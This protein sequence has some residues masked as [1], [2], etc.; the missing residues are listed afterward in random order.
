MLITALTA[1]ATWFWLKRQTPIYAARA[2]IRVEE[3]K[4]KVMD[5]VAD[6]KTERL[7]SMFS[8]NT[9]VQSLL[10]TTLC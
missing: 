7:D 9:A 5:K 10:P 2:V 3:G 8:L 6:V 1:T 4:T